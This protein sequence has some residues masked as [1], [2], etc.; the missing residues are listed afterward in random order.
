MIRRLFLAVPVVLLAAC[1]SQVPST[2][3]TQPTSVRPGYAQQTAPLANGSIYQAASNRTLF[4]DRTARYVGDNITV[5]IEEQVSASSSSAN[6]AERSSENSTAITA[7]ANSRFFDGVLGGL[8]LGT[9]SSNKHDGKGSTSAN[10]TFR[11]QIT[12]QVVEL[13]PNGNLVI[14]GEKQV[15]IRGEISYLRV[16]G[17]VNPSDIK[18][19]NVVSSTKIAEARIE[20]MGSGTVASADRAGWLQRFFFSFLPL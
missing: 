19:G 14:G 16:S 17:I 13:L 4:E 15:N 9:E 20:E 7:G 8:N 18:A 2:I 5:Q 6:K 10:N 1:A 11:G 12:A 3:V